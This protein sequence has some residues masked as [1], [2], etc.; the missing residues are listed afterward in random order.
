[1]AENVATNVVASRPTEIKLIWFIMQTVKNHE[2]KFEWAVAEL[3]Q[4]P[5]K[6]GSFQSKFLTQ[7]LEKIV[8]E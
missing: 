5:I 6:L 4:D 3:G 2:N 8:T 7:I 1:M